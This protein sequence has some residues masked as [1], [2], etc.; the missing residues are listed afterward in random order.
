MIFNKADYKIV[1]KQRTLSMYPSLKNALLYSSHSQVSVSQEP[2]PPVSQ[3]QANTV[4]ST[5][6]PVLTELHLITAPVSQTLSTDSALATRTVKPISIM[7]LVSEQEKK[8]IYDS[9]RIGND[10]KD[11]RLYVFL[12]TIMV[13]N[14]IALIGGS[15]T[16]ATVMI[17]TKQNNEL[18]GVAPL[19]LS[20]I[21]LVGLG[22]AHTR[23]SP[24]VEQAGYRY[25][26][27]RGY[28]EECE[29]RD[30]KEAEARIKALE[31]ERAEKIKNK[32]TYGSN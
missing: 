26:K 19:I 20:F 9:V 30:T 5:A 1:I 24:L 13:L 16:L 12:T 18:I 6:Y 10:Q 21:G 25:A 17:I 2:R 7:E 29:L 22:I 27:C 28:R 14:L 15:I 23:L 3:Q 31:T 8:E 4:Q 11:Y 32:E